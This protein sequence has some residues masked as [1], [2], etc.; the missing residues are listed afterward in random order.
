MD[1]VLYTDFSETEEPVIEKPHNWRFHIHR[2][3]I[4]GLLLLSYAISL[5][6]RICPSIVE[7]DMA[8]SYGTSLAS[9]GIFTSLYFYSYGAIQ[10]FTGLLADVIE[11]GYLMGATQ[12]VAAAGTVTCGLSNSL[13]VGSVGRILVGFGCGPTFVCAN[14]CMVNWFSPEWYAFSLGILYSGGSCGYLLAQTPL[15]AFSERFGWRWAF[16]GLGIVGAV[17]GIVDMFVVRGNPCRFRYKPANPLVSRDSRSRPIKE[18]C[19]A[20][21]RNFKTVSKSWK[22]WVYICYGCLISGPAYNISG[23]W[24]S[25]WLMDVLGYTKTQ[26]A[27]V[28]MTQTI[29]SIVA[30]FMVPIANLFKKKKI[31]FILCSLV[32][33]GWIGCGFM[34]Q[35][36][37]IWIV[38]V[39]FGIGQMLGC[40]GPILYSIAINNF[41][42]DQAAT[43]IG[44]INTFVFFVSAAY[45]LISSV[46]ISKF[47]STG[48]PESLSY[49]ST[50]YFWGLWVFTTAS[51]FVSM[52]LGIF[53]IHIGTFL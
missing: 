12:L 8:A 6:H 23:N 2:L 13:T 53:D 19:I 24:G 4:Y 17:V 9:L 47:G 39:V 1:T 46:I 20:L 44:L 36:I 18:L 32:S 25:Q 29:T 51:F 15:A 30:H 14:R 52:I 43:V 45:Q 10:P 37:A 38:C 48:S 49:T 35:G 31:I 27:N 5:F 26:A 21:C 34:K 41:D 7:K 50:G 40:V 22:V 28:L 16:N 33:I 42:Q 11:P 3:A